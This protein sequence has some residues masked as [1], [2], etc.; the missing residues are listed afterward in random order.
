MHFFAIFFA[1]FCR[2]PISGHF[3]SLDLGFQSIADRGRSE[4]RHISD[5]SLLKMVYKSF[6]TFQ[7]L[8]Y[9]LLGILLKFRY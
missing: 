7:N 1:I 9:E 4:C 8:V 2:T 6:L 3:I 5:I